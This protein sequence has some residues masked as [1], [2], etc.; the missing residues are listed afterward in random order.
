MSFIILTQ[1]SIAFESKA[2]RHFWP[3]QICEERKD[4]RLSTISMRVLVA[5]RSMRSWRSFQTCAYASLA[6]LAA[7]TQK[8]TPNIHWRRRWQSL[9]NRMQRESL[10]ALAA[11]RKRELEMIAAYGK[12]QN[13][14]LAS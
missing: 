1:R 3:R 7:R 11:D 4:A 13:K 2:S 5:H 10:A 9:K 12:C 6:W 14:Q 8:Q